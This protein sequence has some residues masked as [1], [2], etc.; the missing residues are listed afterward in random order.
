MPARKVM[1]TIY[2]DEEQEQ[3]LKD[4]QAKTRVP[5]SIYIRDAV[6][7]ILA[8]NNPLPPDPPEGT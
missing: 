8:K 1:L 5:R 6:D 2:L 3:A 7:M 4:L